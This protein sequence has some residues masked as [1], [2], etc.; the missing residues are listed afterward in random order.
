[1]IK[2][3]SNNEFELFRAHIKKRY[4]INLSDEKKTLVYSRLRSVIE[5]LGLSSFEE[6]YD[7]ILKDKD[8]D[9][10]KKFVDKI[11]T[12]HTFFMREREHFNYLV[13]NVLPAI[14]ERHAGSKDVRLWCAGCSSGEEAYTLQI[15]LQEYF[16]RKSG[17]D[18]SMLATDISNQ[19]LNKAYKGIYPKAGIDELPKEWRTKYFENYDSENMIVKDFLKKNMNFSR[20]NFIEDPFKFK[21]PFQVIFCRNV[22]I[23]FDAE[24]RAGLVKRFY[25]ASESGAYLFIGQ[26]ESLGYSDTEY[27]YIMPA[28]YKK[29]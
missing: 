26:S 17:W 1:M 13:S 16:E 22:M 27:K 23:Y 12:N 14:E 21:K 3:I 4:G 2:S 25:D 10:T 24:T 8:G 6:Y 19:M 11:T 20:L 18:I 28:V 15:L 7:C 29:E 5:Q 9:L